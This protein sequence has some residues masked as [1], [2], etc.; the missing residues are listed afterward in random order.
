M[1]LKNINYM[2]ITIEDVIAR[3]KEWENF[4]KEF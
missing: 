4:K 3:K 2:L 1:D